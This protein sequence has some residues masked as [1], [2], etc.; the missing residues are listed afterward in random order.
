ML[1]CDA[2]I[3][4]SLPPDLSYLS[5]IQRQKTLVAW[6]EDT[7]TR[8]LIFFAKYCTLRRAHKLRAF[9]LRPPGDSTPVP[10]RLRWRL[11]G[12]VG[13]YLCEWV[14]A[15]AHGMLHLTPLCERIRRKVAT[16][17]DR[18]RQKAAE[19]RDRNEAAVPHHRPLWTSG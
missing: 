2:T 16:S 3:A 5:S 6:G 1:W 11:S 17:S 13:W 15:V 8:S 9:K 18:L 10:S 14:G 4:G 19:L 7:R 12:H